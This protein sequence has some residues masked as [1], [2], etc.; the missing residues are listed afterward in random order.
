MF[1]LVNSF[2]M[3]VLHTVLVS[4]STNAEGSR[5]TICNTGSYWTKRRRANELVKSWQSVTHSDRCHSYSDSLLASSSASDG[6]SH[7]LP[8]IPDNEYYCGCE[9][10]S[11]NPHT[12]VEHAL[13]SEGG[14]ADTLDCEAPIIDTG[15]DYSCSGRHEISD[16]DYTDYFEDRFDSDSCV[17]DEGDLD[18]ELADWAVEFRVSNVAVDK[19]LKILRSRHPQLPSTCR[20]LLQTGKV[21]TEVKSLAC[22]E[23][24]HFGIQ[25]GFQTFEKHIVKS[26]QSELLYNVNVDGLPLFKSSSTQLWPILGQ[27][28][29]IKACPFLIGSFCGPRK[30]DSL[31]EYLQD[32]VDEAKQLASVG[33]EMNGQRFTANIACFICDAPARAFLKQIKAHSGYFGCERCVQK[34]TYSEG[35][36]T[37][38]LSN[39]EKRTDD[40]FSDMAYT[41]H[42]L[43]M[44]PLCDLKVGLVSGFVLDIMHLAYLGVMRRLLNRWV[45]GPRPSKLSHQQVELISG[46]LLQLA[47]YVPSEFAR[48]PRSLQE[49]DRWKATEFRQFL[50]YTGI[51]ALKSELEEDYY[52]NFLCLSVALFILSDHNLLEHY[53]N[54]ADQL[55]EYFVADSMRLYGQNFIVYNV[56]NLYINY[57]KPG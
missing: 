3:F 50:L 25:K 49:M 51:V 44:S 8:P 28:V 19:L 7:V 54:Y 33:F 39:S 23:Y 11:I 16:Y 37:Y 20:T 38:P 14:I 6:S 43:N 21:D 47:R 22:G 27:L 29:G 26:G 12:H 42:Q 24:M 56:H 40:L 46:K 17:S 31:E 18:Q 9:G 57:M 52:H 5:G 4:I 32:F 34:G 41:E 45:K 1:H 15:V 10:T 55:L 36:M 13:A 30:P 2:I 53:L 35:R 48:K